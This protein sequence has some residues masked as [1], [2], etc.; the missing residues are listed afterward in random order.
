MA[1]RIGLDD[2]LVDPNKKKKKLEGP[3]EE[4]N[5]KQEAGP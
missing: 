5:K 4:K 2:F 1:C 3:K